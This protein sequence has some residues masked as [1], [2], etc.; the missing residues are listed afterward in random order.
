MSPDPR[1]STCFV[2]TKQ[3]EQ[4]EA[5]VRAG[6]AIADL[7]LPVLAGGIVRSN[8]QHPF[9]LVSFALSLRVR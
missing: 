7:D 8:G 3:A 9:V 6:A 4:S 1:C 2:A 5:A